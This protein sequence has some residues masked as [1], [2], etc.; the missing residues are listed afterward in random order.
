MSFLLY[1][2]VRACNDVTW[3]SQGYWADSAAMSVHLSLGAAEHCAEHRQ[4]L[5][6][7]PLSHSL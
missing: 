1:G 3:V 6:N 2:E 4:S 7:A 5:E